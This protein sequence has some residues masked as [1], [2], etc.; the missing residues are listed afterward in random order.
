M[1][2][3]MKMQNPLA[4]DQDGV[5]AAVHVVVGDTVAGGAVLV[6]IDPLPAE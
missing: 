5:V 4:A 1:L 6:E 3:A 2:E